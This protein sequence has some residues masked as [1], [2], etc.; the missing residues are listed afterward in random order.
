[1]TVGETESRDIAS[2][3]RQIHWIPSGINMAPAVC[4]ILSVCTVCG[5]S[6]KF[7][8]CLSIRRSERL[9]VFLRHVKRLV[10]LKTRQMRSVRI[11]TFQGPHSGKRAHFDLVK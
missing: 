6:I 11:T 1:M 9:L 4:P 7:V 8:V 5:P 3:F 10:H 2:S